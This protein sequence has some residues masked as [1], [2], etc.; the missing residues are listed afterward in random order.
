MLFEITQEDSFFLKF[1]SQSTD[2]GGRESFFYLYSR[3][4]INNYLL[5]HYK[6]KYFLEQLV[7][8]LKNNR[9]KNIC[10]RKPYGHQKNFEY[11]NSRFETLG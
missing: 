9:N 11:S 5:E 4:L 10:A 7:M 1:S 8:H 2:Y 3:F 6:A